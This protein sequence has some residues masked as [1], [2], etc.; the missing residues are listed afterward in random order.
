MSTSNIYQSVNF[1]S[2]AEVGAG[3]GVPPSAGLIQASATEGP[4]PT[5][6]GHTER[7][8]ALLA[9]IDEHLEV[10]SDVDSMDESANIELCISLDLLRE[11]K[12][13]LSDD[14]RVQKT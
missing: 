9:A 11:V 12:E 14:Q 2:A 10:N 1:G 8:S 3:P 5:S 4:A 7:K 6:H 13:F